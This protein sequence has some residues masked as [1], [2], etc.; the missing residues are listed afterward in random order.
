MTYMQTQKNKQSRKN[1]VILK[2]IL[3]I[4]GI[5]VVLFLLN[6]L[7]NKLITSST[8]K[9]ASQKLPLAFDQYRI[10][11]I[12]DVH[13]IR[14]SRQHSKLLGAIKHKNPDIV[15]V[16]GDLLDSPYY[17]E[18]LYQINEDQSEKIPGEATLA[19][20]RELV[21]VAPVYLV[22]GNHEMVLLDDPEKNAFKL[23]LEDIGVIF[24][25]NDMAML[26]KNDQTIHLLG[27]Q[28]PATL[29]KDPVYSRV[30]G[31]SGQRMIAM[32]NDVT[33][34]SDDDKYTILLSHRPE[35]FDL[36][37]SYP[38]DLALTGHAHGG[39]I[40]LPFVGGL[41]SPGQG[42]FPKY[43]SGAYQKDE[44]TMI[45]NRGVGNS[46]ISLRIFNPPQIVLVILI[47]E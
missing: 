47:C 45:V 13:S 22:Y 33:G 46:V 32:L 18:E 38:I 14:D 3:A 4:A 40:R 26:M 20:M 12:S 16:T 36:Y 23:A 11:Q 43:T 19:F 41:F 21:S 10:V 9:V 39:Q 2:I 8:Y 1:K 31:G 6:F 17:R 27:I 25:N 5:F 7:S 28:D 35:Y 37:A 24:L 42:W 34:D 15:V 30:Q 29:Y 44:F